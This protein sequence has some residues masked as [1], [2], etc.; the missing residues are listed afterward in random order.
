MSELL[1]LFKK[2][3]LV[4]WVGGAGHQSAVELLGK[5]DTLYAAANALMVEIGMDREVDTRHPT[6]TAASCRPISARP[7]TQPAW[8]SAVRRSL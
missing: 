5:F 8:R 6:C 1:F 4:F 3:F 2:N 7:H